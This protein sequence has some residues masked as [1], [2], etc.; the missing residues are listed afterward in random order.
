M[1]IIIKEEDKKN[2]WEADMY[3]FPNDVTQQSDLFVSYQEDVGFQIVKNRFGKVRIL[4]LT[5]FLAFLI[6]YVNRY[7]RSTQERDLPE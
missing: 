7:L 3:G 6:T 4:E 2:A 5:E 1:I